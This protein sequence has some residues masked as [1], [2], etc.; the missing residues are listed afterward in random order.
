MS[1]NSMV[2]DFVNEFHDHQ[3]L[4]DQDTSISLTESFE[5]KGLE[6]IVKPHQPARAERVIVRQA[7]ASG[8]LGGDSAWLD[9][10]KAVV[11]Y[12]PTEIVAAYI[13]LVDLVR[14]TQNQTWEWIAFWFFLVATPAAV[15]AT[16]VGKAKN[17]RPGVGIWKLRPWPLWPMI[18]ASISFI[19]W[20]AA[21]P[22][23]VF[24]Y[25]PWFRPALGP[26]AVVLASVM[27]GIFANVFG[28]PARA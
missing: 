16:F 21:L 8:E 27:L 6:K 3:T 1:V 14:E 20:A 15:W 18:A 22:G 28:A 7:K 9:A 17:A 13:P 10:A 2:S 19:A 5:P 24:D 11:S 12:I 4:L 26:V 25:L 23:T